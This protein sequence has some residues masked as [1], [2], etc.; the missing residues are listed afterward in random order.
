MRSALAADPADA[1]RA[2]EVRGAF[3]EAVEAY[4]ACSDA[5][6]ADQPY[7]AA[8]LAVLSPQAADGFAGWSVLA[9]VRRDYRTLGHDV[10]VERVQAA[11]AASPDGP[12]AAEM[13]LWLANEL[14]AKDGPAAAAARQA[15]LSDPNALPAAQAALRS[16]EEG[17][18]RTS[19]QRAVAAVLGGVALIW[20]LAVLRLRGWREGGG[21]R[22]VAVGLLLLAVVPAAMAW[23]WGAGDWPW[24]LATGSAGVV[25][26]RLA[27]GLPVWL[28]ALGTVSCIGLCV[29]AASWFTS[30]G[31][32]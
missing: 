22:S 11:L 1:G 10:A 9:T 30:L 3:A 28:A 6:G 2:A 26:V 23:A 20:M 18:A 24:F 4:R 5:E 8:R 25:C 14:T 17:L 7:C 29:W 32:G 13:R 16:R 19:R 15:V 31:I 21:A 12:A 27:P